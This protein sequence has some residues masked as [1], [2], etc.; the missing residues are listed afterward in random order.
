MSRGK[1][2]VT[3]VVLHFFLG[4][5]ALTTLYPFLW[6][7][8]SSFKS[9]ADIIGKPFALPSSFALTNYQS[10]VNAA[11]IPM[12]YLN[13]MI[14]SVTVT[15][16]VMLLAS[17]AAYGISRYKFTGR[18]W[19]N[20]LIVASMMFPVFAT[21]IPV[22]KIIDG[23]QLINNPFG[24]A[25]PQIAGNMS[26]AMLVLVG[27][28]RGM[29]N[30]IEEAAFIEGCSVFQIF[31]YTVVPIIRPSLA[32]VAIFTF[33]WSYN[34]LFT[35]LFFLRT[36][37]SWAITRLLNEFSANQGVPDYGMMAA[38]IVLVVFPVLIVYILLQKNI[39][40][41]MTAGAVKG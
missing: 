7:G 32:T 8:I 34:D 38:A 20:S 14:I 33:I 13:S 41:G 29:P 25:L 3:Q 37:D 24:V 23:L 36:K 17:M 31:F 4:L 39:I 16:V 27:Y 21:I 10:A 11:N 28:I 30:D 35:Q 26:F 19:L 18:N 2:T 6:V 15:L 40:K 5:W 9:T 1:D 12:A 22:Y